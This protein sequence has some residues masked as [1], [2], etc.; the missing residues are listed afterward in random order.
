M[1]QN[2]VKEYRQGQ[3]KEYCKALTGKTA[4]LIGELIEQATRG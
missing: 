3:K 4:R 1:D 2:Q